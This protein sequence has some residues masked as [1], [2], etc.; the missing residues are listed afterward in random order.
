MF[1]RGDDDDENGHDESD[2]SD[3]DDFEL[4]EDM[5]VMTSGRVDNLKGDE[6]EI[7]NDANDK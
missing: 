3:D 6:L 1:K 5:V 4:L 7:A 2:D